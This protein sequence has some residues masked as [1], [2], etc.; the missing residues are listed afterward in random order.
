MYY[1]RQ[2]LNNDPNK[3][4]LFLNW[5]DISYDSN[6]GYQNFLFDFTRQTVRFLS[7]DKKR[8]LICFR[9]LYQK[10]GNIYIANHPRSKSSLDLPNQKF[11]DNLAVMEK[12]LGHE[13]VLVFEKNIVDNDADN[14]TGNVLQVWRTSEYSDSK[15]HAS[16]S[17]ARQVANFCKNY[18]GIEYNSPLYKAIFHFSPQNLIAK[19]SELAGNRYEDPEND[20]SIRID[21]VAS[22]SSWI[23]VSNEKVNVVLRTYLLVDSEIDAVYMSK[24]D[25]GYAQLQELELDVKP[26]VEGVFNSVSYFHP[27][28]LKKLLAYSDKAKDTLT[29]ACGFIP[30]KILELKYSLTS[31][32]GKLLANYYECYKSS[33]VENNPDVRKKL[34]NGRFDIGTRMEQA[35]GQYKFESALVNSLLLSALL[36]SI[37]HGNISMTIIMSISLLLT[38]KLTEKIYKAPNLSNHRYVHSNELTA[39]HSRPIQQNIQSNTHSYRPTN[40]LTDQV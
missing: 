35:I 22:G 11:V 4:E 1:F 40:T 12:H 18:S 27:P 3:S 17:L 13:C 38:L 30:A 34:P 24:V 7:Q 9:G 15:N 33:A 14:F 10:C 8:C 32:N 39:M 16:H 5:I 20:I 6:N 37:Y 28:T 29:S 31:T 21:A 23:S 36:I 2:Q 19:L 26:N 25:N